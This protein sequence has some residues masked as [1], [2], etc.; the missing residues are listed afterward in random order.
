MNV[1]DL[2]KA[3][4]LT[5]CTSGTGNFSTIAPG[6]TIHLF[7]GAGE[8]VSWLI[9]A[10]YKTT[11]NGWIEFDVLDGLKKVIEEHKT[12]PAPFSADVWHTLQGV[13]P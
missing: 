9:V 5:P 3:L 8:D 13:S 4:N 12:T 11:A 10:D 1:Q 2:F 7:E 6:V